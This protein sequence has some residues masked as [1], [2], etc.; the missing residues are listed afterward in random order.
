M[1]V[2]ELKIAVIRLCRLCN[3]H[4]VPPGFYN[5][6]GKSLPRNLHGLGR[7]CARLRFDHL[8]FHA[9]AGILSY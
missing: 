2:L 4:V 5:H 9:L 1:F 6:V 3:P 8:N 7:F